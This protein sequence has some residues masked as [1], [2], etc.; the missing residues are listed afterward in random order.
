MGAA[1][2]IVEVDDPAPAVESMMLVEENDATLRSRKRRGSKLY[3]TSRSPYSAIRG[4]FFR[5]CE[6]W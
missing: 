6:M 1:G 4:G 5:P 3:D 2:V